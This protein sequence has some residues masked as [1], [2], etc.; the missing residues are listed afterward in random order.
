MLETCASA[1]SL[2]GEDLDMRAGHPAAW[3]NR[4]PRRARVRIPPL[5]SRTDGAIS[6]SIPLSMQRPAMRDRKIDRAF[7]EA[8][9]ASSRSTASACRMLG[10]NNPA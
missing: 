1:F 6:A 3:P 5:H 8:V 2:R 7:T 10:L 4:M 9:V